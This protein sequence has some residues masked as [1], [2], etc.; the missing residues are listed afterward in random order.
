MVSYVL[1]TGASRA[2]PRC[3]FEY[4]SFALAL[5]LKTVMTRVVASLPSEVQCREYATPET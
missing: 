5:L 3:S 1:E 4:R 2:A